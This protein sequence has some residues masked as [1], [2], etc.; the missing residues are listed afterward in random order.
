MHTD[1][2]RLRE[3]ESAARDYLRARASDPRPATWYEARERLRELLGEA[4]P[5][6]P[7]YKPWG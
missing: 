4:S 2:D 3:I 5:P 6:E 7:L 1:R